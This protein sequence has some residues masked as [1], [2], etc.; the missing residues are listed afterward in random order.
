[1]SN[2]NDE[3]LVHKHCVKPWARKCLPFA[4]NSRPPCYCRQYVSPRSLMSVLHCTQTWVISTYS[5]A[6]T[7]PT[8]FKA[9]MTSC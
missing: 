2:R 9:Y 4:V 7:S 3:W 1:M 8:V 5:S 6:H